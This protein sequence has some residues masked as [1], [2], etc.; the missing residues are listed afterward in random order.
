MDYGLGASRPPEG[1]A[2]ALLHFALD[3]EINLIDTARA[4]GES[5]AIIGR[6]LAHRRDEFVLASKVSIAQPY[7]VRESLER[8]LKL[9]RTDR[10]DLV[11]M[12][13]GADDITPDEGTLEV[14]IRQREMGKILF[15]GSSVYG[16][17]AALAA[18]RNGSIDCLQVAYNPLDRR[19]EDEVL[20]LADERDIGVVLRSVLLRGAL[21]ERYR[22]LPAGLDAL[23]QAVTALAE[24][25]GGVQRLPELAY[26]YVLGQEPPHTALVGTADQGELEQAIGYAELGPL[27]PDVVAAVR[28]V[29]VA[30]ERWLNPGLW[31]AS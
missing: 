29:Q 7:E 24:L 13:C 16:P 6:A 11:L 2:A 27:D 15:I 9:L 1:V 30:D 28:R 26:R 12:H 19:V 5:E 4:Y 14:L 21:T 22:Q 31:P 18:I 17:E 20:P 8:S 10:I 23:K 25:A 3:H